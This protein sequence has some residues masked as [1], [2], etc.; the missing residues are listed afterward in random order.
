MHYP[1]DASSA[2][3]KRD[4]LQVKKK[5]YPRVRSVRRVVQMGGSARANSLALFQVVVCVGKRLARRRKAAHS[6][7]T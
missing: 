1:Q 5:V 6:H 3:T 2:G 4:K 7:N